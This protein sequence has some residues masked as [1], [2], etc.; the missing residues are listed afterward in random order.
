M[1]VLDWEESITKNRAEIRSKTFR[2]IARAMAE[3][4]G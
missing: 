2:G 4:W 3:Q 1:N